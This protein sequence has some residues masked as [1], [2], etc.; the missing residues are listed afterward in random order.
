MG[1]QFF[2]SFEAPYFRDASGQICCPHPI[3]CHKDIPRR[4][5]AKFWTPKKHKIT[6]WGHFELLP[7][8]FFACRTLLRYSPFNLHFNFSD[9]NSILLQLLTLA[10]IA[11]AMPAIDN[12]MGEYVVGP[13]SVVTDIATLSGGNFGNLPDEITI[14]SSVTTGGAFTGAMSPF[15]LLHEKG[16]PFISIA[17]SPMPMN[18]THFNF[19]IYV[20]SRLYLYL[21][22]FFSLQQKGIY[23]T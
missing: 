1:S 5:E 18:L 20:S 12:G 3:S 8:T 11:V 2:T 7:T 17:V 9:M 16:V 14:C 13:E 19:W 4:S 10:S 21:L 6:F 15:Q 22:I 23:S